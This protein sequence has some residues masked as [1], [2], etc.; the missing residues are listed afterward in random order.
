[1]QKPDFSDVAAEINTCSVRDCPEPIEP[2][3]LMCKRHW[4]RV[5]NHLRRRVWD[6]WLVRRDHPSNEAIA[7]HLAACV[8]AVRAMEA[9]EQQPTLTFNRE[10]F[11][12][13]RLPDRLRARP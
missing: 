1:M 4:R 2:W 5:P 13:E 7:A 11:T 6:T 10:D 12:D 8:Q 3:K 9:K